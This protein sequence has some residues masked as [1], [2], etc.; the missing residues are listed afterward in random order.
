MCNSNLAFSFFENDIGDLWSKFSRI[1]RKNSQCIQNLIS[2]QTPTPLVSINRSIFI[3]WI[4]NTDKMLVT[5]PQCQLFSFKHRP[6][7]LKAGIIPRNNWVDVGYSSLSPCWDVPPAETEGADWLLKN[8]CT[9]AEHTRLQCRPFSSY[10]CS[11]KINNAYHNAAE[12]SITWLTKKKQLSH[13]SSLPTEEF[14]ET[15]GMFI[16]DSQSYLRLTGLKLAFPC[17]FFM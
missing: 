3:N 10:K 2:M 14:I 17:T 11:P 13:N 5:W 6:W 8:C 9:C 1:A 15:L 12:G 16:G 7:N 4:Q